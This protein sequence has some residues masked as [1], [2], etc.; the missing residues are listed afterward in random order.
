MI[1]TSFRVSEVGLWHM[2]DKVH[3]GLKAEKESHIYLHFYQHL[4]TL[5]FHIRL[6]DTV[7]VA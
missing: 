3:L 7:C 5:T 1:K 4:R 2:G 6:W